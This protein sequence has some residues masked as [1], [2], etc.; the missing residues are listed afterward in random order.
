MTV[1]AR[2][3]GLMGGVTLLTACGGSEDPVPPA[4]STPPPVS[5]NSA[6]TITLVDGGDI[7]ENVTGVVLDFEVSDP[8]GDAIT[9]SLSGP[10]AG[11]FSLDADAF[12]VLLGAPLDFE[13][14]RDADADNAYE[15][16]LTAT[17]EEGASESVDFVLSVLN[18]LEAFAL[19][20]VATGF[21]NPVQ[22]VPVPGNDLLLIVE[23]GG[24]VNV[25]NA[26]SGVT[27]AVP[28]LDVSSEVSGGSEQGLLGLALSPT[29][30]ADLTVYVNLTNTSGDTEIRSYQT[31]AATPDQVDPSTENLILTLEQPFANHNAGWIGFG[32]DGFLLI[33]TGDGGS[34][35]DPMG[36]AQNPDSASWQ[37]LADRCVGGWFSR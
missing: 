25:L 6:P 3:A 26:V 11:V 33:P 16:T 22:V 23:Q 20:T 8:D 34:G 15:I 18:V 28:F 7:D 35:G 30:T 24:L 31:F 21:S 12:D 27:N 5:S 1:F 10:D 36:F 32:N 4:P 19:E 9:V 29:F 14:P 2:F 13:A 37:D 17:D